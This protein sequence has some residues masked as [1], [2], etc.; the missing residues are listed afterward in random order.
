[1]KRFGTYESDFANLFECY[2]QVNKNIVV[3]RDLPS[4]SRS[5]NIPTNEK[6][7]SFKGLKFV[8]IFLQRTGQGAD[9]IHLAKLK[10]IDS[11]DGQGSTII[12]AQEE[13]DTIHIVISNKSAQVKVVD[14]QGNI[15]NEFVTNVA[16][17][18]DQDNGELTIIHVNEV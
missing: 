15:E 11:D 18:F 6:G 9:L 14:T 1:M 17:K 13:E 4:V 16:P 3:E 5:V 8:K 12:T 7:S 2:A 10:S